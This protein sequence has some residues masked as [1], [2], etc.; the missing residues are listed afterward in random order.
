MRI[1]VNEVE[2]TGRTAKVQIDSKSGFLTENF[3]AIQ[4]ERDILFQAY[5]HIAE[6]LAECEE[7]LITDYLIPYIIADE[8]HE[9]LGPTVERLNFFDELEIKNIVEDIPYEEF[10]KDVRMAQGHFTGSG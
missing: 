1:N 3:G 10:I 4:H 2:V 6:I 9:K 7:I 8:V 5:E